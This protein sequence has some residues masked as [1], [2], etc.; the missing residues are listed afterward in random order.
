MTRFSLFCREREVTSV[1]KE[2]Q[3]AR[4]PKVPPDQ[5]DLM[6]LGDPLDLTE[7]MGEMVTQAMLDH[8]DNQ[9]VD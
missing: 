6:V 9:Y 1:L 7:R 8:Q 3:G 5:R 4:D 2:G